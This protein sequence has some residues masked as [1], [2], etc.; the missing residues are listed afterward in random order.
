[1]KLREADN[2]I[3]LPILFEKQVQKTP[4][5]VAVTCNGVDLDV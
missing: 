4:N 3:A 5:K 2:L 1:M